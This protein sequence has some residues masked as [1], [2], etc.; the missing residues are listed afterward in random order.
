MGKRRKAQAP[1]TKAKPIVMPV[2]QRKIHNLLDHVG[3]GDTFELLKQLN[4]KVGLEIGTEVYLTEKWD[5]TTVQATN[6]GIFKR[7]DKF[8]KGDPKKHKATEEE[9][10]GLA[11]IDLDDPSHK[12]IAKSVSNYVDKFKS[13]KDGE[14]VYFEALGPRIGAR[15]KHI[16]DFQDIRVFD[17]SRN[18][19]F[20]AFEEAIVLAEQYELP[21]VAYRTESLDIARVIQILD[22][23]LCYEDVDAPIEGFVI[24]EAGFELEDGGKIAKFRVDDIGHLKL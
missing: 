7:F 18:G 2:T 20:L 9:R 22:D 12:Y 3:S 5:G 4:P 17:F 1:K 11:Q 6:Q 13:L 21:L 8:K 19:K 10:Y 16:P 14:C 24:R 15:Y 23:P